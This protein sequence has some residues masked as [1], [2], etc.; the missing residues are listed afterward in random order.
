MLVHFPLAFWLSVPVLD[1]LALCMDY[2]R[3]EVW[4]CVRPGSAHLR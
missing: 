4:P 2:T 3:G 1:L